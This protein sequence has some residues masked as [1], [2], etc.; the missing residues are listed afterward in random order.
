M[1]VKSLPQR[2][3]SNNSNKNSNSNGNQITLLT[4]GAFAASGWILAGILWTH[5]VLEAHP[6]SSW[7]VVSPHAIVE[8][9]AF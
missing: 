4:I 9:P 7:K 5:S 8:K 1:K 6:N 3:S 2:S